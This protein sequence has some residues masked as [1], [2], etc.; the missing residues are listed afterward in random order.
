MEE[1]KMMLEALKD[2]VIVNTNNVTALI[3]A[4]DPD[5]R[6][7]LEASDRLQTSIDKAIERL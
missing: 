1:I 6:Q 2:Y 5:W 4:K 3:N 7:Q